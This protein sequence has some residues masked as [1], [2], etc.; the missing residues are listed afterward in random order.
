MTLLRAV[1]LYLWPDEFTQ[2]VRS[3]FLFRSCYLSNFVTRYVREMRLITDGFKGVLVQGRNAGAA[4]PYVSVEGNLIVPVRFE[5]ERYETLTRG[6]RHEFFVDMLVRGVE[7]AAKH[8]RIPFVEMMVAIEEFRRGGYVN[9]WI[10]QKKTFRSL[11]LQAALVCRLD[12]DRFTLNL[13]LER[14]GATVFDRKI[15]ETK[16]DEVIFTHRFKDVALEGRN[17]VIT[18]KHG[19]RIFVLDADSLS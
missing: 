15:L 16:P 14:E 13:T 7:E 11:D 12:T 2:E 17:I 19:K 5:Q 3:D 6:E 4:K 8:R 9:E 10:H 18:D 1:R